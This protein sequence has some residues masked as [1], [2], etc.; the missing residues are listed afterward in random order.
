MT[1]Y[2][3]TSVVVAAFTPDV[4]SEAAEDWLL[5]SE[6]FVVSDWAAAEF[7]AAIRNKV[8][9]GVVA[10]NKLEMIE[11]AFNRWATGSGGSK[12]VFAQDHVAARALVTRW[13]LLRAPDALHIA[14][15]LRL[16][17]RFGT[18]DERQAEAAFAEGLLRY[19]P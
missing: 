8:R 5:Q 9:Q 13:T 16:A 12:P 17:D 10:A 19:A 3:D 15:A 6:V 1:V 2:L 18:F 11:A 7:S 4:H 14:I